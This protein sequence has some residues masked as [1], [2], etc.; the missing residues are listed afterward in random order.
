MKGI[1]SPALRL[2]CTAN[3]KWIVDAYGARIEPH[4]VDCDVTG[5]NINYTR[6]NVYTHLLFW[7]QK[8]NSSSDIRSRQSLFARWNANWGKRKSTSRARAAAGTASTALSIRYKWK[9][10]ECKIML[11]CL[12]AIFPL[13]CSVYVDEFPPACCNWML[14]RCCGKWLRTRATKNTTVYVPFPCYCTEKFLLPLTFSNQR[15]CH[16]SWTFLFNAALLIFVLQF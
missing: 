12:F 14:T 7:L 15:A 10:I 11:V 1:I 16:G 6:C 4:L 5:T 8:F 2:F 3:N 13:A 9:K